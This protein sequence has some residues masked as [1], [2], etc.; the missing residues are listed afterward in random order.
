[1]LARGHGWGRTAKTGRPRR[2]TS[3]DAGA[4][5]TPCDDLPDGE[6][7]VLIGIVLVSVG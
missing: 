4:R 3:D 1:M 7:L 2:A 5:V 6:S